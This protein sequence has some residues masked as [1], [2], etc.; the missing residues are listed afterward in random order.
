MVEGNYNLAS[1]CGKYDSFS[2]IESQFQSQ[3]NDDNESKCNDS[4]DSSIIS[5]GTISKCFEKITRLTSSSTNSNEDCDYSLSDGSA[6]EYSRERGC[7]SSSSTTNNGVG[8]CS[9]KGCV[10]FVEKQKEDYGKLLLS[11]IIWFSCYMVMGVIGGTLAFMH[12][13]RTDSD[14]PEPLPDFGYD[15]IP[16]FCP[17]LHIE[18]VMKMNVQDVV[19]TFLYW[20]ILLGSSY[21]FL[22]LDSGILDGDAAAAAA[23]DGQDQQ[24]EQ[25]RKGFFNSLNFSD[26]FS[27]KDNDSPKTVA[28]V[29]IK[30][31][32]GMEVDLVTTARDTNIGNGTGTYNEI[33]VQHQRITTP[34]PPPSKSK[35][36]LNP[37]VHPKLILQQL[38]HL[39]SFL[40]IT[41]TTLVCLT[42][43]P[44]PNPRC[45]DVQQ[46]EVNYAQA[47]AFVMLRGFPPHACGDL[48]YSGHVG[49]ILICMIVLMRHNFLTVK[50]Q[51][52][53]VFALTWCIAGI[54]I[55]STIAC[56]SHYTVDVILAI[57]FAFGIQD[58]YFA[59]SEGKIRGGSIGAFIRWLEN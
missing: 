30:F 25:S 28:K 2:G 54:G 13:P 5:I 49:C 32:T 33:E 21:R 41:R 43:L 3:P 40:F 59:R 42:G 53:V 39:N 45:V 31:T 46:N 12:F 8:G 7:I 11:F 14:A 48:I 57:Y 44:Q 26:L 22:Q 37:P 50:K 47:F 17:M 29:P 38:F 19:L 23:A 24:S 27:G 51:G 20:F 55:L 6:D 34:P 18:G 56:R 10:T 36:N 4:N 9:S 1:D 52:F 35:S 58:F 16:Y 15:A